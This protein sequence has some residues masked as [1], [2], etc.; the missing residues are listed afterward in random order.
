MANQT[1]TEGT[2][3]V[4]GR[5]SL[6]LPYKAKNKQGEQIDISSWVIYF[7]VDGLEQPIREQLV[8]DPN[9]PLGQ[10]IVLERAQVAMLTS[11]AKNFSV[12]DE[13]NMTDDLPFVLWTGK[14]KRVG[15]LGEPDATDDGVA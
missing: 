12:I 15:Y 7:E 10:R 9:D 11:T 13:T 5:G 14:I 6:V 3:E 4:H 2:I 8:A 1:I